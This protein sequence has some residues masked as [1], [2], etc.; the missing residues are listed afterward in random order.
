M[1]LTKSKIVGIAAGL[2][3]AFSS[4]AIAQ[5]KK[6]AGSGPSPYVDC[7]IG[8]ALFPNTSWA[9]ITSNVIWDAGT[10]AVISA[11]AS[12]ETCQANSAKA[13][14]YIFD[15]YDS[16][17]EDTARGEGEHLTALLQIYSCEQD[18][19]ADLSSTIREQFAPAI[20]DENY[21]EL[22]PVEKAEQLFNVVQT[23]VSTTS[24]CNAA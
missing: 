24:S 22:S 5:D 13:A 23:Q 21:S 9:A 4:S 16:V 17:V 20:A 14:Q 3:V 2:A 6:E 18:V 19:H 11:T 7:G 15:V 8:A 10:T 1:K 12:P